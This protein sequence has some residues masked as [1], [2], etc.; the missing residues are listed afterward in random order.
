M[1]NIAAAIRRGP[2]IFLIYRPANCAIEE[3]FRG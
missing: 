1:G 3:T 2:Q